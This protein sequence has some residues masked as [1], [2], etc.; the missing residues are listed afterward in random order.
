MGKAGKRED[1]ET[2]ANWSRCLPQTL[3]MPGVTTLRTLDDVRAIM[4]YLPEDRRATSAW[5]HVKQMLEQA[6]VGGDLIT[7]DNALRTA[8]SLEGVEYRVR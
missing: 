5:Q 2:G 7:V 8:L 3:I 4:R 1:A 6:A